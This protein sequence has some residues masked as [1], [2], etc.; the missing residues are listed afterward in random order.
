[1]FSKI[2]FKVLAV[3][4]LIIAVYTGVIILYVSPQIEKRVVHLEEKTGKAHLQEITTVVNT[5]ARELNSY[6]QNSIAMHKEELLNIT[7]VASRLVEELYKSSQPEQ[8]RE[9][10]LV[11]VNS[12]RDNLLSYYDQSQE[13]FSPAEIKKIIKD[14]V[15]LYRYDGGTG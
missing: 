14:F 2:Y 11:E 12:F 8:I 15:R 1:M 7:E 5:A 6:E 10:I 13:S 3:T 9:H 4:I